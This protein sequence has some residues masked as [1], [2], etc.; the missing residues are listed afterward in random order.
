MQIEDFRE[1]LSN[2]AV[3]REIFGILSDDDAR[4]LDRARAEELAAQVP[5]D[6]VLRDDWRTA[7]ARRQISGIK[8]MSARPI[9]F[10]APKRRA[11]MD[12]DQRVYVR[13]NK[14]RAQAQALEDAREA[15]YVERL[16][17]SFARDDAA[18]ERWRTSPEKRLRDMAESGAE[19]AMRSAA[20]KWLADG[21][22]YCGADVPRVSVLPQ[23]REKVWRLGWTCPDCLMLADDRSGARV[24][25]EP[26]AQRWPLKRSRQSVEWPGI[27]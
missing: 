21:S 1:T 6:Y 25:A 20:H 13:A 3:V 11:D 17:E 5:T 27:K 12:A 23:Y 15:D 8:D 7:R 2:M 4:E 14:A 26:D 24:A 16:Q 9:V 22:T 18:R 19:A 10:G